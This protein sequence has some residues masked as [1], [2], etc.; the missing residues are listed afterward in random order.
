MMRK[1]VRRMAT[2]PNNNFTDNQRIFA[3]TKRMNPRFWSLVFLLLLLAP[4]SGV[5]ALTLA[6]IELSSRLDEPL[7]ARI[8][9]RAFRPADMQTIRVELADSAHFLRAGLER[10]PV[11][12]LL[13]FAAIRN[14]DG[15]AY[16]RITTQDVVDEPF[17]NFIVEVSWSR[18]RILREYTILLDPPV[19]A[20]TSLA[21][22]TAIEKA[23]VTKDRAPT[24]ARAARA[25][26][27]KARISAGARAG[28][29]GASAERFPR[30]EFSRYGPVTTKDTLWSIA[31]R[32]RPNRSV[33]IEQ[34]MMAIQRYNPSAFSQNN[35]NSLK[36]GAILR[37]P[38]LER[39]K[40][41]SRTR[42]LA[43][44]EQQH[45]AWEEIRQKLAKSPVIAPEGSPAPDIESGAGTADPRRSG[46]V[47]I[48]S[49]G[50]AVEGIG[51][52][53]KKG[54]KELRAEISLVKEEL[55]AKSRE[56]KDLKER[57]MEAENLIQEF[58][59]LMEIQSDE[60]NA[61]KAKLV[62]QTHLSAEQTDLAQ[63]RAGEEPSVKAQTTMEPR[64]TPDENAQ[65]SREGDGSGES[66]PGHA[67]GVPSVSKVSTPVVEQDPV[68]GQDEPS[69]T[70]LAGTALPDSGTQPVPQAPSIE[71]TEEGT[72]FPIDELM[73]YVRNNLF[74]LAALLGGIIV[75][76]VVVVSWLRR[77]RSTPAEQN[78]GREVIGELEV[79]D[80]LTV[81]QDTEA[82]TASPRTDPPPSPPRPDFRPEAGDAGYEP[83]ETSSTPQTSPP[84]Q[85]EE[86]A[87]PEEIG[88]PE[89]EE[90]KASEGDD[91]R[92][93]EE[94]TP[95]PV[96]DDSQ[97]TSGSD[98]ILSI[99]PEDDDNG[100]LSRKFD[101]AKEDIGRLDG[102]VPNIA[103][104]SPAFEQPDDA[105]M[106]PTP[107]WALDFAG[108]ELEEISVEEP[109]DTQ[110]TT[111][112]NLDLDF[113]FDLEEELSPEP[114]SPPTP[115]PLTETGE[116]IQ[117]PD[118]PAT[119]TSG[120][121]DEMQTK[122][123]LAQAYIDMGDIEGARTI[124]EQVLA[125]GEE[126]HK[127]LARELLEQ[128]D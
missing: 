61:L 24:P 9:L 84:V 104:S 48:L 96:P 82:Y 59:H 46:R 93:S 89:A 17:L 107:A 102:N 56:N 33:S 31:T 100:L 101:E 70:E 99:G 16:I 85:E 41:L 51:H 23:V 20:G 117:F 119:D 113:G 108:P 40:A 42:A 110:A 97:G 124:L 32:F 54:L 47:E 98:I 115:S 105:A 43:E 81:S 65:V 64:V 125:E 35:I 126:R 22:D 77:D 112:E 111:G 80:E 57:L 37:I 62:A 128:F 95:P 114:T 69:H 7:D 30:K 63:T 68:P 11:L 39:I 116:D 121:I 123:D 45:T 87:K 94:S 10:P 14:P 91:E 78:D 28:K 106:P 38:R 27:E 53:G 73:D 36:A 74:I 50:T 29:A 92:S 88:K 19:Y 75:I 6:D 49:A 58:A 26:A 18:G 52:A 60:I 79:A 127:T 83:R 66:E 103:P 122:L 5:H 118:F 4:I 15:S 21:M 72:P 34:V 120:G 55:D 67:I 3:G 90:H 1:V 13:Q 25:S 109:A 12:N 44:V 71:S 86:S 76:F 2:V 8:P